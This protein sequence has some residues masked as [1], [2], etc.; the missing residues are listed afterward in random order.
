[1]ERFR[2]GVGVSGLARSSLTERR[3][4]VARMSH[5][6][7]RFHGNPLPWNTM[8]S[9]PMVFSLVPRE[10]RGRTS[11]SEARRSRPWDPGLA[12]ESHGGPEIIDAKGCHV[13]PGGIDVH[14]HLE[15]PFCGTVSSDDWNTGTRAAAQGRRDDRD[16]FRHPLWQGDAPRRLSQLDGPGEAQGMCRLLLSY[17][18]HET[19]IVTAP[20]WRNSSRWVARRSRNS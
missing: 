16:R 5:R 6:P 8:S 7:S 2:Q 4:D 14:V 1:M 19:G 18:H 10:K 15:L 17:R 20:R 3:P 11:R 12:A 9:S 13:I